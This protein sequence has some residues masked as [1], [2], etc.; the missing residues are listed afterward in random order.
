MAGRPIVFR[1]DLLAFHRRTATVPVGPAGADATRAVTAD[2]A[3]LVAAIA[4]F[5]GSTSGCKRGFR[6][7]PIAE[8]F[9][10]GDGGR[11]C[12][13]RRCVRST[14]RR[15]RFGSTAWAAPPQPRS[16]RNRHRV[17]DFSHQPRGL[18]RFGPLAAPPE[19]MRT[20]DHPAE[21][22]VVDAP[23]APRTHS[24]HPA[25]DPRTD[26]EYVLDPRMDSVAIYRTKRIWPLAGR[27]RSGR[28]DLNLRPPGPQPGALPDCATP[29]GCHASGRRESNPP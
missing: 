25:A 21:H 14:G 9:R 16:A 8:P 11:H 28:Q 4:S 27:L 17:S 12:R 15:R 22:R 10:S 23:V 20:C 18:K 24:E 29:R 7:H 2:G 1:L 6:A 26:L 13:C 5:A 3:L 19:A